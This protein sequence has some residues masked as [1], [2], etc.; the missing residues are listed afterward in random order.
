MLAPTADG[1]WMGSSTS[2]RSKW[3]R[4]SAG[5]SRR[6]H[7]IPAQYRAS[8]CSSSPSLPA[9]ISGSPAR[10]KPASRAGGG[11]IQVERARHA[12]L[13][14]ETIVGIERG[15]RGEPGRITL[16]EHEEAEQP[17]PAPHRHAG[18]ILAQAGKRLPPRANAPQI[19][20]GGV[21][22]TEKKKIA[23]EGLPDAGGGERRAECRDDHAEIIRSQVVGVQPLQHDPAGTEPLACQREEL[24]GEEPG[25]PLDPRV[26][27]LGDDHVVA[28]GG[29]A[30]KAP[31][32]ADDDPETWVV[33]TAP[34]GRGEEA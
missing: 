31:P 19:E 10:R 6:R 32:I 1:T 26:R 16:T 13:E 11:G 33:E 29:G 25:H 34:L 4:P 17:G 23:G 7:A 22:P 12:P 8:A 20:R 15:L 9:V 18:K 24:H 30:E 14:R 27:G 2:A 21:H 3:V 5:A 28:C